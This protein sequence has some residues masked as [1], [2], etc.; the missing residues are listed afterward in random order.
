MI[1]PV[2]A[3]FSTTQSGGGPFLRRHAPW[4]ALVV[5]ALAVYFPALRA[6][7]FWDDAALTENPQVIAPGGLPAIWLAPS[8]NVNESHYWPL[9]YTTFWAEYRLWRFQPLGYHLTNILL[10]ALCGV[11]LWLLLRRL[12]VP[13]AWLAA[14]LFVVHPV[15]AESVAWVI[16]RKDVLSAAFYLGTALAWLRFQ[17]K[18]RPGAYALAALLFLCA[19][20]SKSIVVTLPLALALLAWWRHGRLERRDWAP[21]AALFLLAL[22]VSAAD[23]KFSSAHHA[24]ADRAL[25]LPGRLQLAGGA[26][27]F[28]FSKLAWPSALVPFYPQ[29]PVTPSKP[30]DWLPLAAALALPALLWGLRARTGRAPLAAM[31]FY[32]LTLSPVLGLV[33][34]TFLNQGWVADRFQYLASIGPLALAAAA[35][36][37]L[38][39]AAPAGRRRALRAASLALLLTLGGLTW[40]QSAQYQDSIRMLYRNTVLQPASWAARFHLG[41]LLAQK[42]RFAEAAPLFEDALRLNTQGY[43]A[44]LIYHNLALCQVQLDLPDEARKNFALGIE[45]MPDYVRAYNNYGALL[46]ELGLT[47]EAIAQF[48]AG[49]RVQPGHPEL[50]AGLGRAYLSQGRL[51]EAE[52]LLRQAVGLDPA[53]PAFEAYLGLALLKEGQAPEA[54]THL[55]QARALGL[56]DAPLHFNLGEAYRLAGRLPEAVASYDRALSVQPDYPEAAQR[57]AQ[58]QPQAP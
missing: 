46:S 25:T 3:T 1:T 30:L 29:W 40:F 22:A 41:A 42:N 35:L 13:G 4:I 58:C 16:E 26:F 57:K 44:G 34:F 38:G 27:W 6:D 37:R 31:L 47:E 52:A 7:F 48:K 10:H 12:A 2:D 18:R 15:H 28:Y 20:L 23:F 55:E 45:K 36:G 9:V 39:E 51:A 32:G 49:L 19:L 33:W 21:L 11:L 54:L 5:L 8:Q 24:M 17:R 56:Q 50:L 14:G 43:G 53:R